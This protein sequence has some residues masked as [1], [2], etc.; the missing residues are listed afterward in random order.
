[1]NIAKGVNVALKG[2]LKGLKTSGKTEV[3]KGFVRVSK[4]NLKGFQRTSKGF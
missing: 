2:F 1:M 4:T 3:A